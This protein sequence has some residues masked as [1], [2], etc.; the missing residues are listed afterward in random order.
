MVQL[1]KCS[2]EARLKKNL[3]IY[4]FNTA[5]SKSTHP[6]MKN[7]PPNGVIG[8]TNEGTAL[9]I[10]LK[11]ESKYSEPEKNTIPAIK[12]KPA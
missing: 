6:K 7:S 3:N 11:E 2:L 5:T 12:E 8:Y 10:A 9:F 1:M 4:F